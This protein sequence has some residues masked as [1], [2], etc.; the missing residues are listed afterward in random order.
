[1]SNGNDVV[2]FIVGGTF[3]KGILVQ[4]Q[5]KV[6]EE[7]EVGYCLVAESERGQYLMIVNDVIADSP[8]TAIA[9][10]MAR[11]PLFTKRLLS[12]ILLTSKLNCI[13]IACASNGKV[14]DSL[15]IP[16]YLSKCKLLSE[17]T[18][19]TFYGKIDWQKRYPLGTVRPSEYHV[20][21]DVSVMVQN[22]FGIFGKSG[23]GKSVLGNLLSA[24]ILLYS[25]Y[26]TLNGTDIPTTQL[27][28]DMHSEYGLKLK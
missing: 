1:M 14:D 8:D 24:Y 21:F 6:H 26:S 12:D 13:P 5:N 15:T 27:I 20:P 17:D 22:S 9:V 7:I 19:E 10:N 25:K 16:D 3:S 2:G 11:K 28:F 4:L 23:T 18:A